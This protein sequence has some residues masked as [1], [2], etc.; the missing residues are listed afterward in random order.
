[1]G[2]TNVSKSTSEQ[3]GDSYIAQGTGLRE[4]LKALNCGYDVRKNKAGHHCFFLVSSDGKEVGRTAVSAKL[5]EVTVASVKAD[6][7]RLQ[8]AEVWDQKTYDGLLSQYNAC[9]QQ[10]V[11]SGFSQEDAAKALTNQGWSV[12]EIQNRS[13]VPTLCRKGDGGAPLTCN[14]L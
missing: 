12:E 5:G 14:R 10:L 11:A 4:Y 8:I 9:L 2:R 1:M 6:A 13:W 7:D 3:Y